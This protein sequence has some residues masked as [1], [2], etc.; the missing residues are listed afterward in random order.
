MIP[1]IEVSALRFFERLRTVCEQKNSLLCVGLDPRIEAADG[2]GPNGPGTVRRSELSPEAVRSGIVEANRRLIT[3]VEPYAACFK[4]NIAF[5]EAYGAPGIQALEETLELIPED[6]PIILD[7]KRSDIGSTARMYAYGAFGHLGVDAV[8]VN[9]YLGRESV[10]PFLEYHGRGLFVLCRTSNPGAE[11]LQDITVATENGSE[12][13]Y[14]RV[15]AEVLSWGPDIGLVVAGN[16]PDAL[17]SIRGAFPDAWIL[18]PGIG[19]QGGD[20]TEAVSA[21]ADG[22]GYGIVPVVVRSIAN[23]GDPASAARELRD[24]AAEARRNV[25]AGSVADTGAR[26]TK[27]AGGELRSRLVRGLVETGCLRLGSFVL[28]SGITS[29]FYIDLRRIQS[30]PR[31]LAAA[32]EAYAEAAAGVDYDR[33]A[34][35]PMGALPVATAMSLAGGKPLIYPRVDRKGHGTGN[36]VEGEYHAGERVLLVDDLITTG[37]SKIEAAAVLREE[38]LIVEE[39]VVLLERGR[40]GRDEMSA[41]GIRLHSYADVREFFEECFRAGLLDSEKEQELL[42]FLRET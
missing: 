18:A 8:T 13:F 12:P 15:A 28:K 22:S 42:E 37:R 19:A 5:Y 21:G 6:V 16:D 38:G 17:A 25:A 4:P 14:L 35:I 30:D 40:T 39:L 10:E 1:E 9:P 32:A 31:L 33:I 27:A 23:A 41:A 7:A 26:K 11:R 36:R 2:I 20:I 34:A 3:A 24:R 29:P